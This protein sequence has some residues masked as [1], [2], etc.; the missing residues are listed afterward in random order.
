MK[1]EDKNKK[2]LFLVAVGFL[3]WAAYEAVHSFL[4]PRRM[5]LN[6]LTFDLSDFELDFRSLFLA[7]LVV[8]GVLAVLFGMLTKKILSKYDGYP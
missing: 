8:A 5:F 4:F 7:G 6:A 1:I 2:I 3:L